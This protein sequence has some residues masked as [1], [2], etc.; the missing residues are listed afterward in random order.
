MIKHF[1]LIALLG[2]STSAS[3]MF[4]P[5]NFNQI[6]LGDTIPQV[7]QQCG[8]PDGIKNSKGE[9]K[10]PQEWNFYVHPEMKKY[11]QMR[12]NS[13]AEASVKMS[14]AFVNQKVV[15][16]S[17]NGMS[18]AS[19]TLCG[20]SVTVGDD[21]KSVKEACGDPAFMNKNSQNSNEKPDEI[22]EYKYNSTPPIVL[23]FENG[24]LTERK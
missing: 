11:T 14:V 4:C 10:G 19:T 5:T 16:I 18:L 9:D 23:V 6:N 15:N 20:K 12:T 3:A 24:K 13:G 8:K 7:E 2:I 22:V 1:I 17:A 21:M